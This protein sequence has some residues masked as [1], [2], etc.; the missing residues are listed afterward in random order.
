M[1]FFHKWLR[2]EKSFSTQDQADVVLNSTVSSS[3]STN[4]E[5]LSKLFSGIPELVIRNFPLK[6]DK[7]PL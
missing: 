2:G 7:R 6:T 3:I 4:L 5:K 1:D